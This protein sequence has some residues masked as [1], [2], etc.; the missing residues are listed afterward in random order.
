MTINFSQAFGGGGAG[1]GGSG[2]Y[3]LSFAQSGTYTIPFACA[4]DIAIIGAAGSGASNTIAIGGNSGPCGLKRIQCEA[5]DVID[6][7]VGSGGASV[8]GSVNGLAGGTTTVKLNGAVV[9]T[10]TGGEGG[11]GA[12]SGSVNPAAVVSTIT[13][14]DAWFPGLQAGSATGTAARTGG[15][16]VNLAG[17]GA[18]RSSA[19]TGGSQSTAGGSVGA[20]I[21]AD[22]ATPSTPP[23]TVAFFAYGLYPR[24]D[25]GLGGVGSAGSPGGAGGFGG[26]G[27]AGGNSSVGGA[28]GQGAGGGAC[29]AANASGKG[30]NGYVNLTITKAA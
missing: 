14:A 3:V 4:V 11:P 22:T 16:A 10:A 9:L 25:V 17:T 12:T 27:G 8:T 7:A 6:V 18:G 30:G 15:A 1:A 24:S 20:T 21:A 29:G 23:P 2:S 19:I 13:G 28:G 26:G 5:G